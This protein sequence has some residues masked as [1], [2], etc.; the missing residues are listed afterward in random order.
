MQGFE[1]I[2][3]AD[4]TSEHET[5]PPIMQKG[6][7]TDYRQ[8]CEATAFDAR[9]YFARAVKEEAGKPV[10]VSAYGMPM[11]NQHECFIK[12][13]GK[14]GKANDL[15]ASMSYYPYRQ[16]GF[17]SGYH[18]EQSFGFHNTGFIQELD[19]TI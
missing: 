1:N 9:E 5:F 14:K 10:F 12:M 13:A 19:L 3:I 2:P 15:I 8:F 18:P 17:A 7:L 16:P 4:A 11:E 6:I